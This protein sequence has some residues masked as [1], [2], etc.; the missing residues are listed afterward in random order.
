MD[1]GSARAVPSSKS[2]QSRV[3]FGDEDS[4]EEKRGKIESGSARAVAS[5]G[6]PQSRVPLGADGRPLDGVMRA[7]LIRHL[8][9]ADGSIFRSNGYWTKVYRLQDA[10]EST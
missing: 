10:S 1:S 8:K 5:A 7:S 9:H 3:T 4:I 6:A 2:S